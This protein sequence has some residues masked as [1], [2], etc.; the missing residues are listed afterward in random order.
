MPVELSNERPTGLRFRHLD[1][2]A[3]RTDQPHLLD[4][5]R[6]RV[7]EPRARDYLGQAAPGDSHVEASRI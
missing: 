3:Q 4:R 1:E 6:I 5:S 7:Q 2:A